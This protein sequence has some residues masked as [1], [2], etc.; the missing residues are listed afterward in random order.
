MYLLTVDNV[1]KQYGGITALKN[2]SVRVKE[3]EIVGLIGPNGAGKTTLFKLICGEESVTRGKI[4][5]DNKEITHLAPYRI[6]RLG[7]GR[8]YQIVKPIEGITVLE[9]VLVSALFGHRHSISMR[10]AKQLAEE[11][12]S[13]AMLDAKKDWS[14]TSLTLAEKRKLELARAMASKPRVL[15]L[16]EIMSGL[17]PA[18]VEEMVKLLKSLH[19]RGFTIVLIEHVMSAVMSLSHQVNVLNFGELIFSGTPEEAVKDRNVIK[20]YLGEK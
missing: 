10:A 4:E 18:E 9:N 16:D 20:A 12:V 15:L 6:C 8:T 5:F 17:T 14:V 3:G 2:V 7:I 19:Q 13:V 1:V 11:A